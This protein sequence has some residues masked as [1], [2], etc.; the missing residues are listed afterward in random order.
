M[1]NKPLFE[2]L[3]ALPLDDSFILTT[4]LSDR[5]LEQAYDVELALRFV[6]LA[7]VSENKIKSIGDVGV[8]LTE[9]MTELAFSKNFK[10]APV[11][12]LFSKTFAVLNE[13]MGDKAFKRFNIKKQKHE[14]GFL[15]SLYETI[16]LGVAFNIEKGTLCDQNLI[17]EKISALWTNK[18][19][20][21][22]SASG[23][24]ASRR[25]PRL[26]PL[27]RNIFHK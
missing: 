18:D 25:L 23:V 2:W 27:G 6:L 16:A 15:L 7:F 20:T 22:W 11:N 1:T 19:F 24:T 10:K 26:I 8:F 9:N 4:A 14:G 13:T 3:K 17:P 12:S 21:D 5:P